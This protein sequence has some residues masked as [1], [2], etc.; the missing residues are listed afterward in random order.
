MLSR[1]LLPNRNFHMTIRFDPLPDSIKVRLPEETGNIVLYK[2]LKWPPDVGKPLLGQRPDVQHLSRVVPLVQRLRR[3]DALVALQSD[4]LAPEH[5]RERLGDLGLADADLALE[6]QRT[7]QREGDEDRRGQAAVGE[8]PTAAQRRNQLGHEARR[9]GD[10]RT[11]SEAKVDGREHTLLAGL[12]TT[13]VLAA[14]GLGTAMVA[15][16]ATPAFAGKSTD[17]QIQRADRTP[18]PNPKQVGLPALQGPAPYFANYVKQQL[19]SK[20]G[21]RRVFGGG[22]NVQSRIAFGRLLR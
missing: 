7:A 2:R 16:L 5:H 15:L 21:T 22:L 1:E 13:G 11:T 12:P 17:V 20:Y 3:V 18:L 9:G 10:T 14:A 8:V 19:V 4:Q 6:Q